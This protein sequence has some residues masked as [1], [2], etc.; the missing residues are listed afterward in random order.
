MCDS[1]SEEVVLHFSACVP[2]SMH[3]SPRGADSPRPCLGIFR[4][5]TSLRAFCWPDPVDL[6]GLDGAGPW[7]RICFCHPAPGSSG[8][9]R[10]GDGVVHI[11]VRC[12]T[13]AA[14]CLR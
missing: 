5:L 7:V 1:I 9:V 3:G 14:P 2:T 6:A 8:S 13:A 4:A 10:L 11:D 12:M